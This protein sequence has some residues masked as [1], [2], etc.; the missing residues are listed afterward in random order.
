M[1]WRSLTKSRVARAPRLRTVPPVVCVGNLTVGGTGKT[2][3]V[4]DLLERLGVGASVVS[5]GYGGQM[6]GPVCVDPSR[7]CAADVGDEPLLLASFAPVYVARKRAEAARMAASGGAKIIVM[8]DGFQNP[9]VAKDLS[10]L[11]VD[12]EVGFG[13]GRVMP[14]GPL[15]EPVS[16]GIARA[17]MVITIGDAAAQARLLSEW[18]ELEGVPRVAARLCPID[19]GMPWKGLRAI[20][21]AG[22]GRPEKFFNTLE[23]LG[24]DLV[25]KHSFGDHQQFA[26]QALSRLAR[27]ARESGARLVTTEKDAVRLPEAFRREVLILPVRLVFG[28]DTPLERALTSLKNA[29]S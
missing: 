2:P 15:R 19:M 4:L 13:N 1:I 5:R 25:A 16:E 12:A 11:V 22:I 28:D 23:G 6:Q 9:D 3:V 24:V 8:D 21:F 27:E 7:H 18:P 10:L 29:L 14:S 26:P 17:D 20:A